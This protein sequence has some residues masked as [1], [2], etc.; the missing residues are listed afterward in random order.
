M[1]AEQMTDKAAELVVDTETVVTGSSKIAGEAAEAFITEKRL[2][3][4]IKAL[5]LKKSMGLVELG[6]HTGPIGELSVAA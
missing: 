3:E 4:R 1:E 5:R 6:K 2:G